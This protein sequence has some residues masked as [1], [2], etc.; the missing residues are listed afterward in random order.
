VEDKA[1]LPGPGNY[2]VN[3]VRSVSINITNC[4][5]IWVKRKTSQSHTN[6]HLDLLTLGKLTQYN[7]LLLQDQAHIRLKRN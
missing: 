6:Q 2:E 5:C 3:E 7:K 4:S 1:L